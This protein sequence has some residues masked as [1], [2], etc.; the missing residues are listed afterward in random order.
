MGR[1]ACFFRATDV[2]KLGCV[3][4]GASWS[5]ENAVTDQIWRRRSKTQRYK[6]RP[7]INRMMMSIRLLYKIGFFLHHGRNVHSTSTHGEMEL[8][9][10]TGP[11][12]SSQFSLFHITKII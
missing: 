4:C 6:E 5:N 12:T 11:Q 9:L 1:T 10:S 7:E 3:A 8:P 2:H